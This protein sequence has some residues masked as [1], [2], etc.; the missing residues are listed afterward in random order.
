MDSFGRIIKN[1]TADD[2]NVSFYIPLRK[3]HNDYV[4]DCA[5]FEARGWSHDPT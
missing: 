5:A 3:F 2:R 1:A 4:C